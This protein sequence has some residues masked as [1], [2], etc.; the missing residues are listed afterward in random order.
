M[1]GPYRLGAF[2]GDG[3]MGRVYR[4]TDTRLGR[5]VAIKF[6][7]DQFSDHATREAR[8]I[9]ALNHLP[10]PGEISQLAV[11]PDRRHFALVHRVA[12]ND[13]VEL[14]FATAPSE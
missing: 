1:I 8:A 2:L 14:R 10:V 11:S 9:A 5:A 13:L 3:G 4:A 12:D 6:V 7:A